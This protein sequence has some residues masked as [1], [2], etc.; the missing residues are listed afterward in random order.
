MKSP[1]LLNRL[2]RSST[3][4]NCVDCIFSQYREIWFYKLDEPGQFFH[5]PKTILFQINRVGYECFEVSDSVI[6]MRRWVPGKHV[7]RLWVFKPKCSTILTTVLSFA[8]AM[9]PNKIFLS[10][11]FRWRWWNEI[12]I[13]RNIG[14]VYG[15]NVFVYRQRI[16]PWYEQEKEIEGSVAGH[17]RK[18]DT[19]NVQQPS[20]SIFHI[21]LLQF[22]GMSNIWFCL[23]VTRETDSETEQ[24]DHSLSCDY[25]NTTVGLL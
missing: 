7:K 21:L 19:T 25:I 16:W 4:Q 22:E 3:F 9:N 15:T 5:W 23:S 18:F 6:W 17:F 1:V 2:Q 12:Q 10:I 11:L 20:H 13:R 14:P 24:Q 8:V